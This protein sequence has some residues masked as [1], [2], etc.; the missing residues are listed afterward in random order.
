M[1]KNTPYGGACAKALSFFRIY[2][3]A[4]PLAYLL[5]CATCHIRHVMGVTCVTYVTSCDVT[6]DRQVGIPL[7]KSFYKCGGSSSK[8]KSDI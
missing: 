1:K 4:T 3:G 7:C 2:K 5:P 6:K 8:G